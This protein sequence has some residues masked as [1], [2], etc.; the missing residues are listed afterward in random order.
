MSGCR[1]TQDAGANRKRAATE[2]FMKH[3]LA[4]VI[5]AV[6]AVP[7]LAQ[8]ETSKIAPSK[9]WLNDLS[10]AKARARETGKPLFVVFRC[11]P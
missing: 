10:V 3:S 8:S 9:G 6:A 1:E 5:L 2:N 7:A 11:D 4:L